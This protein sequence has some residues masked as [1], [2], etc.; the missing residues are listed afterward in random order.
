[1]DYNRQFNT[2]NIQAYPYMPRQQ[3]IIPNHQK[4]DWRSYKSGWNSNHNYGIQA[5]SRWRSV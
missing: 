4:V 1:M 2:G 3:L 5:I